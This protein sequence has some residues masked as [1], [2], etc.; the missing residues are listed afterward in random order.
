[1]KLPKFKVTAQAFTV[2]EDEPT[3]IGEVRTEIFDPFNDSMLSVVIEEHNQTRNE[4]GMPAMQPLLAAAFA[5]DLFWNSLYS[6]E[7]VVIQSI[8]VI[9]VV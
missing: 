7:Q 2:G 8:E 4:K 6:R 9:S 5:Y 1:M 3:P